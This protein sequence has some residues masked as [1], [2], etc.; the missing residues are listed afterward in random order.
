[1]SSPQKK[2]KQVPAEDES[3][4]LQDQS[5]ADPVDENGYVLIKYYS[6]EH[7]CQF[8]SVETAI[9]DQN[10]VPEVVTKR[11]LHECRF[12]ARIWSC[13]GSNFRS[14]FSQMLKLTFEQSEVSSFEFKLLLY[15]EFCPV[16]VFMTMFSNVKI[17]KIR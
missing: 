14:A 7:A 10:A 13:G 8:S 4:E 3:K 6:F 16:F 9:P 5:A 12:E 15:Q 11:A 1:M 17:F 2:N